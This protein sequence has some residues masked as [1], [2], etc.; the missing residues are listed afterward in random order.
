MKP[1]VSQTQERFFVRRQLVLGFGVF[2]SEI[3]GDVIEAMI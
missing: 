2:G 3:S 1:Q